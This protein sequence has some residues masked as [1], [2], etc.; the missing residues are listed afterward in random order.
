MTKTRGSGLPLFFLA[1]LFTTSLFAQPELGVCD[2]DIDE[3]AAKQL[4]RALSNWKRQNYREAERYLKRAVDLDEDYADALYL[5]GELYVRKLQME[6]SIPL[7]EKVLEVCPDYKPEIRYFLGSIFLAEQKFDSA[8]QLFEY[9]L[10]DPMRDMGY[11]PEVK[12][13]LKE[14][15]LKK[16]L[17]GEPVEFDPKAVR[18][19]G[20]QADEYLAS[21]SP[22]QQLMFFTRRTKKVNRMD[23]PAA[24]VRLVE[25]F[26][27][28]ERLPSGDFEEGKPLPAPFNQ[29]YNEGGPSITAD[30]TE[31]Y[32]TVCQDLQGYKNCDVY[33]SEKLSH[34]VWSEPQSVGDHINRRD[35]WESQPSISANGDQMFFASNRKGGIGGLDIYV[36]Q[37]QS[38]GSWS[39][40]ENLGKTINTKENE[41][42]PFIH[43]DSQTLY[44]TSNGHPGL[45]GYD[46]FLSK[47][48]T[49][50]S[51]ST[52][53]NIGYPINSE[54]DD[55]SLFVS[56]DGKTAYFASNKISKANGWDIYSFNLPEA[57]KPQEVVL[58][59][60]ELNT[61]DV[62]SLEDD[63][64]E[65]R[66]LKT[67]ERQTISVDRQT[68]SYARVVETQPGED[69]I[70]S[71]R[72]KG[73]AFNSSYIKADQQLSVVNPNIKAQELEV[74]KEY[75]LNDIN[76][77]S[78]SYQLDAVSRSVINEFIN[79]LKDNPELQADIQG[80]T[81]NI[82]D[83]A[84]NLRLSENRARTVY[85]FV[86]ENGISKKRLSYHGYGETRPR[87]T[88]STEEGRAENRRTVFVI[89][90]R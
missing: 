30:N 29:N 55:L 47:A 12:E 76:F 63:A 9:Y 78:N 45:G 70:V 68:G 20:T 79:Y 28:A 35:A 18:K 14:A 1:F 6:R 77:E 4:P 83:P 72:Q 84:D 10:D 3:M 65:L 11:D 44:F 57:A 39:A 27:L 85:N 46:I 53:Q 54:D 26:S 59:K 81:D 32:F 89:T 64:I 75:E 31:L 80:H 24:R 69:L 40:P 23:G 36:C 87:E 51:W 7:W 74:G 71:I 82:G 43:S 58:I 73:L 16:E 15:R 33:F 42:T 88:N 22:D 5:L 86:V 90:S 62:A 2:Q 49:D 38:D 66:N 37:R 8:I 41:K 21:I 67:N 56:L 17:L 34:D 52:P 61:E 25:E 48:I 13:A 50:T 19:I 60:G